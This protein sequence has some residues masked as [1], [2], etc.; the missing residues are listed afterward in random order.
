[1]RRDSKRAMEGERV[2]V[3]T[4]PLR[5]GITIIE[6]INGRYSRTYSGIKEAAREHRTSDN[7]I[8]N[9]LASGLPLNRPG[10]DVITF[11]TPVDSPYYYDFVPDANGNLKATLFIELR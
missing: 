4:G 7:A 9:C 3:L 8:K 6:Q 11:D 1:M 2:K 10:N 5:E